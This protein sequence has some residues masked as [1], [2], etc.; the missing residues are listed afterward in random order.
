MLKPYNELNIWSESNNAEGKRVVQSLC[1][2]NDDTSRQIVNCATK[3]LTDITNIID[4]FQ[5][6]INTTDAVAYGD[7][8]DTGTGD[9][10]KR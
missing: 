2:N 10:P 5:Y 6:Q 7:G 4:Y 3:I 9:V 1:D 8:A